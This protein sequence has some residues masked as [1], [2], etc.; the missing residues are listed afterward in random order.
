MFQLLIL[1]FVVS[2]L[3]RLAADM[4]GILLNC[5]NEISFY[6]GLGGEG[7]NGGGA[8]NKVVCTL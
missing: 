3:I 8:H 6:G 4:V 1:N 2:K 7:R 5:V